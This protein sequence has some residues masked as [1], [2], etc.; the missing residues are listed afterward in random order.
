MRP[1]RPP[2]SARGCATPGCELD[3]RH[4]ALGE[5]AAGR[6]STA[7]T[8]WSSSAARSRRWTTRRPAPSSCRC[9]TC[10]ARRWRPTSRRWPSASAPSCWPRSAAAACATG[11]DGPEVGA[12]A[13]GQARRG[14]R[15]PGVRPAA[16]LARRPAV[17]PR[18]D[19]RAA[20]RCHAAGQQPD[21]RQPG[22]P[23]RPARLRPAVPH[24][25]D[26]GDHPRVGRAG[27]R[28]RRRQ[29][30]RPGDDLPALR[31]GAPAHRG[32]LGA[33]RRAVRR[34]GAGPRRARPPDRT[35]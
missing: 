2:V 12:T 19:R 1:I 23:G 5:R 3:E 27:R 17:P 4:L 21:V 7:T 25:D 32:G 31:R 11:I 6:R 10:C 13:G 15:G 29:P 20:H 35:A 33:V 8:G 24:R 22:V 18:R 34:P 16:A 14:G 30:A 28:R 9:A 26:A